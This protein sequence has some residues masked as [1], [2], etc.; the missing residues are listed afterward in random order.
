MEWIIENIDKVFVAEILFWGIWAI[1]S[2]IFRWDVLIFAKAITFFIVVFILGFII[3]T[4]TYRLKSPSIYEAKIQALDKKSEELHLC[5]SKAK[6]IEDNL[7]CGNKFKS[8]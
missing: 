6:T 7:E 3:L 5:L 1:L 8:K 2:I 4:Q